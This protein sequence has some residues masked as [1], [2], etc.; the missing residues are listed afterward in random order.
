MKQKRSKKLITIQESPFNAETPM[1]ALAEPLIPS[2]LFYVRNHFHMIQI[3][4]ENWRLFVDGMV[5]HP[6]ELSLKDLH[7][8]PEHSV[9]VTLE[10]A[11]NGRAQMNP[12][13]GGTAW[14]Y[15]AVSTAKFTGIPL[16]LIL[17]QA[18]L[19]PTAV[20]VLFVGADQG[21]VETGRIEPFARSLPLNQA[22]HPDTL[23]AWATND[24]PLPPEH[25]FP[26]R[27]VVPQWYGMASVKWLIKTTVL[28]E[29]FKGYFQKERYLYV[30][31]HGTPNNT[32]VTLMR[33]RAVIGR[34]NECEIVDLRPVEVVGIAW[35]GVSAIK[36]VEISTDAGHSW[37]EAELE[38]APSSY[39]TTPWHFLWMPPCSGT[40]I[41]MARATDSAGNTQPLNS[42]WNAYGYGNN[43]VQSVR[44]TV[45]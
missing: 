38:V 28:S 11:G 45:R 20:E 5:K 27:L 23:L 39:A 19:N 8:L 43:V 2:S 22:C 25:G 44:V 37:A 31:E 6:L 30:G 21:E 12:Q 26:L 24:Q 17:D 10:C 34:P 7:S 18:G 32:P 41:L 13:P 4:A 14:F 9:I 1:E 33:V 3:N 42:I 29:P 40:Y 16:H 36:R 35:S 15:G